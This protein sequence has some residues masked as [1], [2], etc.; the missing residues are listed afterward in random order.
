MFYRTLSPSGPLPCSPLTLITHYSG[1]EPVPL[2]TYSR[3]AAID[4]SLSH[5]SF[6]L[7]I[8]TDLFF[9]QK[10]ADFF[11]EEFEI[12]PSRTRVALTTYAANVNHKFDL[13]T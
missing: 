2:T 1:R 13:V 12:G 10:I 5:H 6:C 9:F 3:W 8:L 4:L 7:I 11:I